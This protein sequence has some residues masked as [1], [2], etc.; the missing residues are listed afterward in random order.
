MVSFLLD[1]RNE[2]GFLDLPP[3]SRE[4][5]G[6]FFSYIYIYILEPRLSYFLLA[7]GR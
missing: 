7:L 1:P 2:C 3:S 4:V 6:V 5:F